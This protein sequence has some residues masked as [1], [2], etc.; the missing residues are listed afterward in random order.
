[1]YYLSWQATVGRGLSDQKEMAF[2]IWKTRFFTPSVFRIKITIHPMQRYPMKPRA[3]IQ[4]QQSDQQSRC[5]K[6]KFSP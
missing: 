1:M 2:P 4:P 5:A 3:A 6:I